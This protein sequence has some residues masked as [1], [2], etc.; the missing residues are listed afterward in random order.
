MVMA[1]KAVTAAKATET[2]TKAGTETEW[3]RTRNKLI[4]KLNKMFGPES[5]V[6]GDAVWLSVAVGAHDRGA[7]ERCA[8][9]Y[10][11]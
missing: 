11:L 6:E 3:N 10:V 9:V 7:F 2:M 5:I 8:C 4:R 1:A